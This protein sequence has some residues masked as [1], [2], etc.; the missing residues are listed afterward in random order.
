VALA[1]DLPQRSTTAT[2]ALLAHPE[3]EDLAALIRQLVLRAETEEGRVLVAGEGQSQGAQRLPTGVMNRHVRGL[4]RGPGRHAQ[5]HRARVALI[6][7]D[8]GAVH[9]RRALIVAEGML[10]QVV[11][12]KAEE[13]PRELGARVVAPPD[14]RDRTRGREH[15]LAV[16]RDADSALGADVDHLAARQSEGLG[17][18][19]TASAGGQEREEEREGREA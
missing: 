14:G 12:M 4:G 3:V 9:E 15:D 8:D 5:L 1:R 2:D 13:A 19:P 10:R 18:R 6:G 11:A 17:R 7:G 16:D